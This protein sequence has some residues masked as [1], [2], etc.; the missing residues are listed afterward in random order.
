MSKN[1]I[2]CQIAYFKEKLAFPQLKTEPQ[3]S[4]VLNY[5]VL[6]RCCGEAGI[7]TLGRLSPATVFKTVPLDHSGTSPLSF[8]ASFLLIFIKKANLFC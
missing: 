2:S 6:A 1:D 8:I 7:R 4:S 5:L 3:K